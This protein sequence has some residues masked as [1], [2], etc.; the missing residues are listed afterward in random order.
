MIPRGDILCL[1]NASSR[2]GDHSPSASF[3]PS[4]SLDAGTVDRAGIASL[5]SRKIVSCEGKMKQKDISVDFSQKS[6]KNKNFEDDET[7]KKKDWHPKEAS[8]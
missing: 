6:K 2:F 5:G 1:A 8:I 7:R 4:F 3:P